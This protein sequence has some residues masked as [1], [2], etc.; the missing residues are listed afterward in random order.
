MRRTPTLP[1]VFLAIST[2]VAGTSLIAVPLVA[3]STA[4]QAR[5]IQLTGGGTALVYDGSGGPMLPPPQF[6]DAINTLY[7]EPGGFTGTMQAALLPNE[8]YPITG[9]KS[10]GFG[11]S[12]S[13]GQPIMLSDIQNQ[14]AAGGVTSENPLVVFGYSQSAAVA[15]QIM[16]Q[17]RDAGVPSDLVHFVLVGD[18]NNPNGGLLNTFD[19]PAGNSWAFTAANFPFSPP[20][21]SDLYPTDIYS[22]EY[23]ASAD[24]PRYPLNL[25]SVLNALIGNFT[26]HF[27][28]ANL[29]PEQVESA[30]LLPGSE[31]LSGEGLT[32]YYMIPSASLPLLMP[33]LFLPGIGQPLYDLLEP[34]TRILVNLGYGSI[35]EGWNQGP[36]N[37]PTTFGLFPQIDLGQL[38]TALGNG[39][40]QGITDALNA[41]A[42][43]VSYEEQIAPW[44]PFADSLYTHGFAPEN[45][46]FNDVMEGLLTLA[47]FP[48]SDVTLNSPVADIITMINSTL[49]YDY[50]A[51]L[52]AADAVSALFTSLPA[53]AANIFVDQLL[54]GDLLDAIGLP[55]AA[56]SGLVPF[57][58]LLG[59]PPALFA[60]LG[61]LDNFMELFS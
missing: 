8:L 44:L 30:I 47:G 23:D 21:P 18:V 3:A 50:S 39:L 11:A 54:V 10:M 22:L 31:A 59:A 9:V 52:P 25:L 19:F 6:L 16:P 56:Y 58:L 46:T 4:P 5:D 37:V 26:Q 55:L 15:S 42:N 48:V 38:S 40:Q 27:I 35:D 12:V 36:A 53:Y 49:A 13:H 43:P 20:T 14:I 2:V 24:F 57:D 33:L 45:P 34:V 7:L 51:L 41:L 29:T 1:V 32:E 28:Y 17:L 61:T 60:A